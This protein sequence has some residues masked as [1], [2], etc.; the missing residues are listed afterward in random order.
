MEE[1]KEKSI[2]LNL[3]VYK[4]MDFGKLWGGL[5]Y[6]RSFDGAQYVDGNSVSD[7]RLQY[8]TP[9]VGFTPWDVKLHLQ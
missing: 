1:T 9:I 5:S 3:K 2:D 6:R 7:Q 8:F 4:N